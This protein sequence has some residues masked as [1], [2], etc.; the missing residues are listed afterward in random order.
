[1]I[2]GRPAPM[3]E[4]RG[5]TRRFGTVAAVENI[6]FAVPAG[7][8]NAAKILPWILRLILKKRP[9]ASGKTLPYLKV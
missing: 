4:V 5:L 2:E 9:L 6:S 7:E 1:M 8:S 3:L